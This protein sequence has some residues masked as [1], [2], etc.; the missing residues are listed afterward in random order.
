MKGPFVVDENNDRT[1]ADNFVECGEVVCTFQSEQGRAVVI[2]E[3]LAVTVDL[4]GNVQDN[5]DA[6]ENDTDKKLTRE[7][8]EE[9]QE[10][11]EETPSGATVPSTDPEVAAQSQDVPSAVLPAQGTT[12][13][14]V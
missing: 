5:W 6:V 13:D 8:W 3:G 9:Q 14:H 4:I 2:R 10:Q 7:E 12:S 11:Q 1:E